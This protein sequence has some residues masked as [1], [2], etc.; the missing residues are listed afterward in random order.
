MQ[1]SIARQ[2]LATCGFNSPQ[3]MHWPCHN[4]GMMLLVERIF[5][6][7]GAC[8]QP[9]MANQPTRGP[10]PCNSVVLVLSSQFSIACSLPHHWLRSR[11][12][13]LY[14][15]PL[16]LTTGLCLCSWRFV[17]LFI[18][19]EIFQRFMVVILLAQHNFP[20]LVLVLKVMR[21]FKMS[22]REYLCSLK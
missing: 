10:V 11:L 6:K 7:S 3:M 20:L 12:R 15:F 21:L 22:I 16:I 2:H 19:E 8:L 9:G 18:L 4:S 17:F 5:S 1:Q 13:N 14:I